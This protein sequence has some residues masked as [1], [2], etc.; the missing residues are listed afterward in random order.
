MAAGVIYETDPFEVERE[1]YAVDS[2]YRSQGGFNLDTVGLPEKKFVPV[3]CPLQID[4]AN[5]KAYVVNNLKVVE[6][7]AA[8][9]TSIKIAKGSFAKVGTFALLSAGIVV[10]VSAVDA[11]EEAYDELT[12][13]ALSAAIAKGAVLSEV[14]LEKLAAKVIANAAAEATSVK[15]AKGSGITGAC[16]L[17]D[18]T[19]DI[20]VSAVDTSRADYDTLTVAALTAALTAGDVIEEKTGSSPKAIHTATALN[21]ARTKIEAGATITALY[22]AYEIKEADLYIPVTEADKASLTSRFMFE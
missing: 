10:I 3:L 2:G 1:L 6:A 19:N 22:R 12:V 21:Y 4:Y 13:S 15:I 14:T 11:S 8:A 16:T 7:A 17:S 20:T 5:R 9:A 18:G